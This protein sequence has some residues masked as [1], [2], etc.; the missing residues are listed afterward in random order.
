MINFYVG[1]E[2]Q[3][4][5]SNPPTTSQAGA[6]TPLPNDAQGSSAG[7]GTWPSTEA[8]GRPPE[9]FTVARH[10]ADLVAPPTNQVGDHFFSYVLTLVSIC[11]PL[12]V[13]HVL[14]GAHAGTLRASE[15]VQD[16]FTVGF[17]VSTGLVAASVA[18]AIRLNTFACRLRA[19]S[20][21]TVLR[22][23]SRRPILL[24]RAFQDDSAPVE[25][26]APIANWRQVW[27]KL[28]VSRPVSFE[29]MLHDLF[30]ALGPVIAIG[31][32]GELVPPLGA[33][34]FWVS[35]SDWQ[36][37]VKSLLKEAQ[38]VVLVMGPLQGREGLTWEAERILGLE[39][40][41]KAVLVMPPIE[42][43]DARS[44]W[45]KY[46]EISADRL[47]A[48][49]GGELAVGFDPDGLPQVVRV[50]PWI[51]EHYRDES[52]YRAAIR[53][54]SPP[55]FRRIL[56]ICVLTILWGGDFANLVGLSLLSSRER[57]RREQS[58][59]NLFFMDLYPSTLK[60]FG[61]RVEPVSI[62]EA[63]QRNFPQSQGVKVVGIKA[64]SRAAAAGLQPND[65]LLKLEGEPILNDRNAFEQ[66][67]EATLRKPQSA[68]VFFTVYR[69]EG[70]HT[71]YWLL[72][73]L[74]A[75][76]AIIVAILIVRHQRRLVLGC[77]D[78]R[79]QT[80][81]NKSRH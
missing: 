18:A 34:R 62:Q 26:A 76:A 57:A 54:P 6:V 72:A 10:W 23:D 80:T 2:G 39:T 16:Y 47:P 36:Q 19:P 40:P 63:L 11:V 45:E 9:P 51:G 8:K 64:N 1:P 48:Y 13:S 79:I 25:N 3:K 61:L 70:G 67:L 15:R 21:V 7:K 5:T 14:L 33:A 35:H 73:A 17:W 53:V 42:E 32:P 44:R 27:S 78:F 31:R 77:L 52:A 68:N 49:Q 60:K 12:L 37:A 71:S 74:I 28:G 65:I 75:G 59:N 20:A 38:R 29:E 66:Q 41:Q 43:E 81:P 69:D 30:S 22:K 58:A 46:R 50:V 4:Q 55:S 56:A 24:L